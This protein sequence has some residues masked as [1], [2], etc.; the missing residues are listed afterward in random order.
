MKKEIKKTYQNERCITPRHGKRGISFQVRVI[1]PGHIKS[2]V[3][4]VVCSFSEMKYGSLELAFKA[5]ILFRENTERDL[6]NTNSFIARI[7]TV[8]EVFNEKFE[9]IIKSFSTKEKHISYYSN[10]ISHCSHIKIN[11]LT[12]KDIQQS[13]NLLVDTK[14]DETIQRVFSIWK[15]I[16]RTALINDYINY[17]PCIKVIVP[18]SKKVTEKREVSTCVENINKMINLLEE[19]IDTPANVFN[20]KLLAFAIKIMY[21]TGL[22]P[23]EC[24][25]LSKCDIDLEKGFMTVTKRIGSTSS[26]KSEVVR[27][28]T[29][30]SNRMIPITEELKIILIELFEYQ[31]SDYLFKAYNGQFLDTDRVSSKVGHLAKKNGFEFRLYMLRHSVGTMLVESNTDSRT[32]M[33]ILGHS[34][35]N[36]T[37]SYARSNDKLKKAAMK[38]IKMS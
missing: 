22:R 25:A 31:Q 32:A 29:Q 28:K 16:L 21:Y 3:N 9:I 8:E 2:S 30:S 10:Y 24:Y 12:A 20:N 37:V 4:E 11:E 7:K 23:S 38:G 17:D 19:I 15:E 1:I 35:Y 27:L 5:A 14:S 6:K 13:L 26:K 36:M 18:K 34:D 33:E